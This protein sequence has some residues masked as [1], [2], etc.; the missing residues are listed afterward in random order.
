MRFLPLFTRVRR[1]S[2][3]ESNLNGDIHRNLRT[4]DECIAALLRDMPALTAFELG[5][6][7]GT[8]YGVTFAGAA[9]DGVCAPRLRALVV[10]RVQSLHDD[11]IATIVRVCPN[12]RVLDIRGCLGVTTDGF[13]AAVL[14]APCAGKGASDPMTPEQHHALRLRKLR[15][16]VASFNWPPPPRAL[17]FIHYHP[18]LSGREER[19]YMLSGQAR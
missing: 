14:E 11:G 8:R 12:L 4:T 5:S 15:R 13:A 2:L 6:V 19:N 10:T 7:A 17:D 9:Y 1:L 16:V 3:Q 18:G